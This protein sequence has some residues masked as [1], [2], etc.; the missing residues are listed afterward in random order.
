VQQFILSEGKL[1]NVYV[2]REEK[3]TIGI[4]L[5][6]KPELLKD[7]PSLSNKLRKT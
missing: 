4:N 1:Q 2:N 7:L 5:E 3:A 6:N